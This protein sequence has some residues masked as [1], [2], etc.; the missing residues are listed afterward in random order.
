ML[1]K[2]RVE[3]PQSQAS[4]PTSDETGFK[5]EECRG[6]YTK[7]LEE[8][9]CPDCHEVYERARQRASKQ[10]LWLEVCLGKRGV[11]EFKFE[12][13]KQNPDNLDAYRTTLGFDSQVHN[14][15]LYGS[16]GSGKTHLAGAA[17]RRGIEAGQSGEFIKHPD[18]NRLFRKLEVEQEKALL[19]K[20]L[21][22]DTLVIDDLGVGRSTEFANQIV[23]EILDLRGSNYKNGLILTSNLSLEEFGMKSGDDRLASRIAGMCKIVKVG[24]PDHRLAR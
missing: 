1:E 18:L 8:G 24:G 23:Y 9:R 19:K 10:S 12:T 16:C 21:E 7:P 20:H 14:L 22:F 3:L 11:Q 17:W 15:Y 2:L 5:C 4:T 6:E 13:F